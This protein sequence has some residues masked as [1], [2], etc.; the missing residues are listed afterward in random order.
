MSGTLRVIFTVVLLTIVWTFRRTRGAI[1]I[2]FLAGLWLRRAWVT[3]PARR[4]ALGQAGGPPRWVQAASG[5]LGT[6]QA[7]TSGAQQHTGSLVKAPPAKRAA[8]WW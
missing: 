8:R 2:S 6:G 1:V 5:H 3:G 7:L 4:G